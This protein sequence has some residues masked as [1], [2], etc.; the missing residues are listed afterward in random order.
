MA[1]WHQPELPAWKSRRKEQAGDKTA[2]SG[3]VVIEHQG[4]GENHC[5]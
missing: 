2:G 1:V 4:F 5:G 3:P